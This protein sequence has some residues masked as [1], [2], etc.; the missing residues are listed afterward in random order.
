MFISI[1]FCIFAADLDRKPSEMSMRK[2]ILSTL[3]V[4]LGAMSLGLVGCHTGKNATKENPRPMMKYGV[5]TE[6]RVVAMY[7]VPVDRNEDAFLPADT[8][9]VQDTIV[10]PEPEEKPT[11]KPEQRPIVKYGVP[12]SFR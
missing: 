8:T 9:A 11:P 6:Q 3:N 7:G 4:L 1:F 5:P 10:A 12:N 2:H